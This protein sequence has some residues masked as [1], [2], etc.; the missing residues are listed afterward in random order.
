MTLASNP[1]V[2][3]TEKGLRQGAFFHG[4]VSRCGVRGDDPD[5]HY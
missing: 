4:T 5:A 1:R 3:I 2:P